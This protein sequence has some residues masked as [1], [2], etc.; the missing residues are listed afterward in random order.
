[1]LHHDTVGHPD[2]TEEG[3]AWFPLHLRKARSLSGG[4]TLMTSSSPLYLPESPSPN[5]TGRNS[6]NRS[7]LKIALWIVEKR[8]DGASSLP[9]FLA[10]AT[11]LGCGFMSHGPSP[12]PNELRWPGKLVSLGFSHL[13]ASVSHMTHVFLNPPICLDHL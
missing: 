2:E 9:T 13:E 4:P 10:M 8:A 7:A 11:G 12:P 3:L 6:P 1:M 5:N